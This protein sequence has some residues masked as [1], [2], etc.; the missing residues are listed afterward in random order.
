[1]NSSLNRGFGVGD[2]GG[3][4]A[5]GRAGGR[6]GDTAP[7]V[8]ARNQPSNHGSFAPSTETRWYGV[9]SL[10]RRVSVV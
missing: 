6:E 7:T 2:A 3:G 8:G 5:S 4:P 10:L 1:M 9:E